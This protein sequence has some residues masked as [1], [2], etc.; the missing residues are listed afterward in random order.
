MVYQGAYAVLLVLHLLTVAFLVG[1]SA[2]AALLS[3]GHARAGRVDALRT[4][5]RTTRLY[6]MGTLVTVLLG[7][8]LVGASGT[9][10]PTWDMGDLWVAGSYVLWFVAVALVLLV[11]VPA[12]NQAVRE[13]EAG[14]GAERL[15]PRIGAGGG[16]AMLCWV[17]IIVLMV[18]KP[19]A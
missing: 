15:A 3:P 2:M 4:A 9:R 7:S 13:L 18:L 10:T 5:A 11:V 12:Q 8:A 17:A 6:T 16:V 1:P 19:G 14:R